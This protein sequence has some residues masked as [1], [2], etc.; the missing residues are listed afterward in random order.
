MRNLW[1]F[2]VPVEELKKRI[3]SNVYY[4]NPTGDA[5]TFFLYIYLQHEYYIDILEVVFNNIYKNLIKC[6]IKDHL[7]RLRLL[8]KC[9]KQH[10]IKTGNST[11]I[12]T[13][14]DGFLEK[15]T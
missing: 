1:V 4:L 12:S 8:G 6:A 9:V 3:N 2:L 15:P 5:L 10:D 14:C 7:G 11:C 13:F